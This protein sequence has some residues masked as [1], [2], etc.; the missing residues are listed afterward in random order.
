MGPS[1]TLTPRSLTEPE[2][3]VSDYG[4]SKLGGEKELSLL[5]RIVPCTIL[6]PSSV[7]G[8][9]DKDIFIFFQL[10]NYG[11]RPMPLQ[12]RYLQLVYVKDVAKSVVNALERSAADNATLYLAEPMPYTWEGIGKTIAAAVNRA[13]IPLPLPDAVF[14]TTS[15]VAERVAA[16][17][18]K[19]AVLNRQK[20][21]EMMQPYWLGDTSPAEN[22][23][24]MHFTK[25]EIG[26]KITYSW[27]KENSWL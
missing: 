22:L 10:V 12:K 24:G 16:V 26:A 20:I 14:Y 4:L 21:D 1:K 17:Q 2:A 15:F 3:P 19:P 23:L 13:T 5:N 9:R 8:P 25:L 7:Y 6:R 27:Y 11:F 18:K